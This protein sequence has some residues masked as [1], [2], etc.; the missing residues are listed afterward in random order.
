VT[1]I[2]NYTVNVLNDASGTGLYVF[3]GRDAA[4]GQTFAVQAFYP[5][6]NTAVQLPPADN[7][8]GPTSCSS[9]L[10]VVVNNKVYVAGGFNG[11]ATASRP[12][13]RP[14]GAIRQPL[15]P[16]HQRRPRPGAGLHHGRRG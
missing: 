11:T 5:A 13:L 3:C 2:S 15:D 8:P 7:Y 4:A 16:A 14:D 6:T 10:N 12:G 1:P 9:A